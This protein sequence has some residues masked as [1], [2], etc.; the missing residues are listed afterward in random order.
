MKGHQVKLFVMQG[1]QVCPQMERIFEEMHQ[2]GAIGGLEILD[3]QQHPKLAKQYNI[4]SVPY[5]LIDG[6]AFS[7]LKSRREIDQLLHQKDSEKWR[8]MIRES[9]SGGELDPVE[10]AVRQQP[11][12]GEAMIVLLKDPLT[13]LLVRIGLTAV[14]ET[15]AAE[16]L[17]D[18]YEQQFIEMTEHDDERIAVDALYYLSLINTAGSLAALQTLAEQGSQVM[19]EHALELLQDEARDQVLH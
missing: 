9:L 2:Q 11:A 18:D 10:Q 13:P 12:A 17:L 5:Y 7:G 14:I 19:R 15:L 16:G 8:E 3:V 6:V 1:C 4:R